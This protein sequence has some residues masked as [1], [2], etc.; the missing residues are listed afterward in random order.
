MKYQRTYVLFLWALSLLSC[1][2]D[3]APGL[4]PVEERVSEAIEDLR[5]ALTDPPNGWK[6]NYQPVEGAGTFYLLLN[7]D[8][9]GLVTIQSDVPDNEG[10]FY[11]QTIPYRIDNAL[12]LELIFETFGVFHYL[13][14][15][16]QASFGAEFEFRYQEEEGDDL[17]FVSKSDLSNPTTI[18]FEPAAATDA[19]SFSREIA[20]NIQKFAGQSPVLFGGA[21]PTMHLYLAEQDVSVFWSID[22]VQ[23]TIHAEISGEGANVDEVLASGAQVINHSTGFAFLNGRLVLNDPFNMAVGGQSFELSEVVLSDFS[24]TGDP[25]CEGGENPTPVYSG[26]VPGLG[27]VTIRK[28][29]FSN[30]GAA[31]QPQI[32]SFYLVN[33]PFI[34]D[35][36]LRSLYEEGS[37]GEKLPNAAAFALFYGFQ[38]DSIPAYSVG[39]L[40]DN[41]GEN[42]DMYLR[43][44]APTSPSGNELEVALLDSYYYTSPPADGEEQSLMEIT[45]E[46][47]EGGRV[48]A[49]NL[50]IQGLTAFQFYNP[51]N[52]YEF[53]LVQ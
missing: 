12:G 35:A 30:E 21:Q 20:E 38:S 50:P 41:G 32:N 40:M 16:E 7:F 45:N 14:E 28:S 51:C 9:D 2:Q 49:F 43:E 18:V 11:E 4:A 10:E 44:F 34:F 37:I 6:V 24:L 52:G 5:D 42:L 31:F 27:P 25:L 33:I 46:I 17:I 3:D 53:V 8:E 19:E 48:Y 15:L 36:D 13:F 1:N 47:F 23:R 29:L 26:T 22:L 39:F